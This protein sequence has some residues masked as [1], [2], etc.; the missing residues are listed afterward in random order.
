MQLLFITGT[1]ATVREGSGTWTGISTLASALRNLGHK[2]ALRTL[3]PGPGDYPAR[4]TAFNASL[5]SLDLSP[6]DAVVGFDMD[7]HA[8]AGRGGPP[9]IASIKG[10]IADEAL[11]EEAGTRAWM[12]AQA[13]LEAVHCRRADLV[14]T[15]SAYSA[16][17]LKEL[18]ALE[19]A[20]VIVPE[21]IDLARWSERLSAA[22]GE[23][24][25]GFT[26]LCVCR[27]Y[28]RKRVE[29][30]LKAAALLKGRIAG[31][32]VRVVG[33]GPEQGRLRELH[34][35]L[36]LDGTVD[37]LGYVPPEELAAEYRSCNVF[38]LP[39]VQEGFGIVL[40]EAMAAGAPIVASRAAAIPEVAMGA[41][42]VKPDDERSLADALHH[43]S[44][45]PEILRQFGE[46]GRAGVAK[47]DAPGVASQFLEAIEPV[48]LA[49]S[50]IPHRPRAM[51]T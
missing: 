5:H 40:L 16:K 3:E 41:R 34:A 24:R 7:G 12:E 36:K 15:T 51:P 43:L 27:L 50:S 4:R 28:R 35:S 9:H 18:Y 46:V 23:K 22:P 31:L 39:S 49:S 1:P 45:K 19:R 6:F 14:V 20:P 44:S 10:V 26:V 32:R 11:F 29:V 30:L 38:C 25:P 48:F 2:V 8:L 13:A 42:L 21:P 37:W 17:R 33:D 47:Y